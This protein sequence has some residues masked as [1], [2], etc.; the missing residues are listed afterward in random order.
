MDDPNLANNA[1]HLNI[2]LMS[3]E[4]LDLLREILTAELGRPGGPKPGYVKRIRHRIGAV[5][6]KVELRNLDGLEG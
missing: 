6:R 5:V 4:D 1:E 3:T 2:A